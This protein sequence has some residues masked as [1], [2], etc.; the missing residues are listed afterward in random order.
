MRDTP[1]V[2]D[3]MLKA[4]KRHNVRNSMEHILS[5]EDDEN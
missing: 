2:E 1:E 3:I 5:N 4:L